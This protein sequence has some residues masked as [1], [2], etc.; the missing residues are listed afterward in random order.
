MHLVT[1]ATDHG[2][3]AQRCQTTPGQ[4]TILSGLSLTEP[5]QFYDFAPTTEQP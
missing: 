3:V 2:T 1:L 5:P 4:R